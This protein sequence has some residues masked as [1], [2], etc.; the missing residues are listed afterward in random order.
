MTQTSETETARNLGNELF[1]KV[2]GVTADDPDGCA[3]SSSV[4]AYTMREVAES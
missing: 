3:S 1:V 4:F 2:T